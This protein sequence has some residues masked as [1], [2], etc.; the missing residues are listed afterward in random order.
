MAWFHLR[1]E[2]SV[3]LKPGGFSC[4]NLLM[5]AKD[6]TDHD[7]VFFICYFIHVCF[8]VMPIKVG[9]RKPGFLLHLWLILEAWV[10]DV[11]CTETE[12]TVSWLF[13]IWYVYLGSWVTA[14]WERL[15]DRHNTCF[16]CANCLNQRNIWW[17]VTYLDVMIFL[18]MQPLFSAES[19]RVVIVSSF[20]PAH[21]L[22]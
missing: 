3:H 19:G 13:V 16:H 17:K 15:T 7:C 11:N 1:L 2:I 14:L 5:E 18:F 12:Q 22:L 21:A 10:T 9:V 4:V 6:H 20:C 8:D